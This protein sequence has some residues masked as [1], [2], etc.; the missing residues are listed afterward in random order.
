MDRA[1]FEAMCARAA[2]REPAEGSIIKATVYGEWPIFVD[3]RD[4]SLAHW[5]VT[6]GYWESWITLAIM[7]RIQPDWN[8]VDIGANFGY[9]SVLMAHK[10]ERVLAVDP[11]P[12]M[13]DLLGR[14]LEATGRNW[15]VSRVAAWNTDDELLS[16][17]TP[18]DFF[19]SAT[20]MDGRPTSGTPCASMKI[21]TMVASWD[22]VDLIKIDAEGAEPEIWE[23]MQQT[24][25]H[26]PIVVLEYSPSR[27]KDAAGFARTIEAAGYPLA[28]ID[29]ASRIV[30]SSVDA[31]ANMSED[32]AML[33]LE[34]P[35]G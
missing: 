8:C 20:V 13:V 19:G 29:P 33:W 10:G 14:T 12:L 28:V 32:L 3:E 25:R 7:N 24:L 26:N 2:T 21:D 30:P 27:Y 22:R 9:Y 23:G 35:R 17:V 4:K 31:L 5:L 16:L 34:R 1:A 11:S 18:E 15:G 6:T